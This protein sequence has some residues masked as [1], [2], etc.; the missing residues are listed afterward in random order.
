[1]HREPGILHH[2]LA[3]GMTADDR[4]RNPNQ[5]AMEPADQPLIGARIALPQH[6]EEA[7]VVKFA[8]VLATHAHDG[9]LPFLASLADSA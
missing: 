8:L 5:R 3:L 2:F 4:G 1:M 7:R 6:G 9:S